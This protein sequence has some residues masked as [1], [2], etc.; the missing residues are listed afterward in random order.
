M[1]YS[2]LEEA[3][4][5]KGVMR[6]RDARSKGML[7]A[8]VDKY[9]RPFIPAEKAGELERD[10]KVKIFTSMGEEISVD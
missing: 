2:R 7:E 1:D 8:F 4:E 10:A 6:I 9:L 3:A 5:S